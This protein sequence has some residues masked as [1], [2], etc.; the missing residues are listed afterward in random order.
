MSLVEQVRA[1]YAYSQGR[2]LAQINSHFS[3][4]YNGLTY[5]FVFKVNS[6]NLF[7]AGIPPMWSVDRVK[8]L[9]IITFCHFIWSNLTNIQQLGNS[10]I[11]SLIITYNY[12]YNLYAV[13]QMINF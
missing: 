1:S 2:T 7:H 4:V 13:N 6:G 9:A 8:A 10:L 11:N 12:T 3:H 5:G